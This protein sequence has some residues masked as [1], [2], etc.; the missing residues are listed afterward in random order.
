MESSYSS[1]V[2]RLAW[3]TRPSRGVG[4]V[5]RVGAVAVAADERV[6]WLIRDDSWTRAISDD[7]PAA[8]ASAPRG[9]VRSRLPQSLLG[10]R[11]L[12]LE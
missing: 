7:R 2:D 1:A 9:A 12:H 6:E 3:T 4:S 5:E 10:R 11:V 8:R